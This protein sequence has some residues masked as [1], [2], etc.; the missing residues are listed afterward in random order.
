MRSPDSCYSQVVKFLDEHQVVWFRAQEISEAVNRKLGTVACAL[1]SAMYR[2]DVEV[3]RVK[4]KV[5]QHA[6]YRRSQPT[7]FI[8]FIDSL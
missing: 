1:N 5:G 2:K 3:L 6:L 7:A 8:Q 4:D